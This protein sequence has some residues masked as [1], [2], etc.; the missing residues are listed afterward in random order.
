MG[1]A[2]ALHS[3]RLL[4]VVHDYACAALGRAP[5]IHTRLHPLA[6][7]SGEKCGLVRVEDGRICQLAF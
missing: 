5:C 3:V 2:T 6:T 7:K 4:D 1:V